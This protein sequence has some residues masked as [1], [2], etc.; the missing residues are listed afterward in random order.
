[1]QIREALESDIPEI[2]QVLKASLGEVSS[3]KTDEVWRF[4]HVDNPFGKSLIIVAVENFKIIGVRAFMRWEW[5]RGE[6]IFYAFRAVDTATHPDHQGKGVFKK[7]TLKAIETGEMQGDHFIFNTPNSQ[8]LPGYLKMGWKQLGKLK[9]SVYFVNPI[10]WKIKNDLKYSVSQAKFE[11]I[12]FLLDEHNKNKICQNKL[13][14]PI[15]MEY[16]YWRYHSNPLQ[17]YHIEFDSDFYLAV[18]VKEHKYF[19]EL[20]IAEQIFNGDFGLQK[21]NKVVKKLSKNYGVQ[22][23]TSTSVLKSLKFSGN[24]GPVFTLKN[25]NLEPTDFDDFLKLENWNYSIGDLELF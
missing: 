10:F 11:K 5:I 17:K 6:E 16:L 19:R 7:L 2:L 14:T 1:M 18:Y 13:F 3:K 12:E 9:I 22:I 24:F 21:I 23:I 25:I 20:R 15:N 4:K 8:S